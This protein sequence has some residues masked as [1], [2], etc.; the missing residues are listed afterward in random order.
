MNIQQVATAETRDEIQNVIAHLQSAQTGDE[1][2]SILN[3]LSDSDSAPKK[4]PTLD[5]I[6]F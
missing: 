5:E 4:E 2:M 1:L 6:E 3:A